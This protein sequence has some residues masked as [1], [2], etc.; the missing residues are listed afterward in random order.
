MGVGG[1]TALV[2]GGA[3]FIGS[4]LC[5]RLLA[6]GKLV[7]CIDNFATGFRRNVVHLLGDPGFV[8]LSHDVTDPLRIDVDEIY[9]LA[10]PASPVHYQKDPVQTTR[11]AVCGVLNMLELASRLGAPVFQASTSEVYGDPD[12]HPQPESYWGRVNA[13]GPRACY[14]EGKRCAESLCFDFHRQ[15]GLGVRVAR[16][17][18]CYGPRMHPH[19]GRVIPKFI[20][21]AL[22]GEPI[23][24]HGDGGQTRSFCYIDDLLDG[25]LAFMGEEDGFPG[26]V[27]LGNPEELSILDVATEILALSGSKSPL[28]FEPLPEDGPMRRRPD[29]GLAANRLRWRPRVAFREGIARTIEYFDARLSCRPG[30]GKRVVVDYG[31]GLAGAGRAAG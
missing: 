14:D 15:H 28:V 7:V 29:I 24:I 23:P 18:N 20:V 8:L 30:V 16:I 9:N 21:K 1:Q 27:N 4:H 25:I 19:D 10:C 3:G 6:A 13:I 26:P 5:E 31:A 17:F 11:T 2:T 12:V 22:R